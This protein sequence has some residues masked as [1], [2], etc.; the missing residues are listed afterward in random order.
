M[1]GFCHEKWDKIIC[2]IIV[3]VAME[4]MRFMEY[5][6]SIILITGNDFLL[7]NNYPGAND[8]VAREICSGNPSIFTPGIW[9]GLNIYIWGLI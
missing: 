9:W 7:N 3:S 4:N 5:F 2:D 1:K 6:Y 8:W